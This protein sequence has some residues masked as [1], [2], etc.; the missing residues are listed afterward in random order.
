MR[1]RTILAAMLASALVTPVLAQDQGER[2]GGWRGVERPDRGDVTRQPG[3][4][5]RG[6]WDQRAPAPQPM[7]P[8]PAPQA[9]APQAQ[10][11]QARA[12]WSQRRGDGWQGRGEAGGTGA[13]GPVMQS[14]PPGAWNAD[15]SRDGRGGDGHGTT[16]RMIGRPQWNGG[17]RHWDGDH[18]GVRN[19]RGWDRNNDGRV[20]RRWDRNRD[21]VIDRGHDWNR[22]GNRDWNNR[23]W[24]GW[25]DDHGWNRDW[26]R[27][28]R[29]DWQDWR[30]RNRSI[31]RGPRFYAPYGYSYQRFGIGIYLDDIFFGSRY[32]ISDPWTYRLPPAQWPYQWVRYY[33][34]VLLVDTRDGYVV[35]VIYDFFW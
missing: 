22:D 13:P 28:R 20:D 29:Y 8:L 24:R 4:E 31:F 7:P 6:G 35:D 11:P 30:D 23:N 2:R 1:T 26:R 10:A 33:D 5:R 9:Q 34:D 3:V 21:G 16:P 17:N 12:D 27:D 25:N 14:G 18:D 32:R 19:N 15:R